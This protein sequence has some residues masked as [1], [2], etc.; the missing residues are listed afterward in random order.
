MKVLQQLSDVVPHLKQCS[1]LSSKTRDRD[2]IK[3]L[4][5]NHTES[6]VCYLHAQQ[7]VFIESMRQAKQEE[8]ETLQELMQNESMNK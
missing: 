3:K 1:I 6:E 4:F 8:Q 2:I 5:D 7:R